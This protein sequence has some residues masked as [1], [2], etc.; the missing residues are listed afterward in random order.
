MFLVLATLLG[1]ALVYASTR[2][3][4]LRFEASLRLPDP[5]CEPAMI[6]LGARPLRACL[7]AEQGSLE[8]VLAAY[9]EQPPCELY[10]FDLAHRVRP[11]QWVRIQPGRH[12]CWVRW[13]RMPGRERLAL[14]GKIGLNSATARD[15]DALPGVGPKTALAILEARA[16]LGV[17]K[18]VDELTRARGIGPKTLAKIRPLV[19]VD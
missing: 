7:G 17:F 19:V 10:D 6:S 9:A 11:W 14:G 4:S 13:E 12:G 16:D 15:L 1:A 2:A 8:E 18:E 3:Q 5:S